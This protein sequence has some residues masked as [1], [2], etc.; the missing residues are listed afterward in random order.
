MTIGNATDAQFIFNAMCRGGRRAPKGWK[1]VGSGGTR[2]CFLSPDG[3]VYKIEGLHSNS[4]EREVKA[5]VRYR[6]NKQLAEQDVFIPE[7]T[8]WNVKDGSLTATV[9]AMEYIDDGGVTVQCN[10][11]YGDDCNCRKWGT[12]RVCYGW[13]LNYISDVGLEDM[14]WGNVK[15]GKDGKFYVIDL[16]YC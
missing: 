4:N 14:F 6:K 16:G 11:E 10:A 13:L 5:A 8:G 15:A 12:P 3:V 7:T 1:H 2:S 9:V